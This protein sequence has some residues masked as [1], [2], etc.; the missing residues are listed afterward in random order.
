MEQAIVTPEGLGETIKAD[1]KNKKLSQGDVGK[2]VG[3]EQHTISKF[4]AGKAGVSLGTFFRILSALE[5]ELVIRPRQK[6][7]KTGD[8]W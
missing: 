2:L 1:R 3:I 7:A 5:L 8:F 4:E 6:S